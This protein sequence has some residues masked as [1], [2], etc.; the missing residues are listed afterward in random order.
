M[1]LPPAPESRRARMKS[2]LPSFGIRKASKFGPLLE[3][4]PAAKHRRTLE[5]FKAAQPDR[6]I[7]TLRAAL[8]VVSAKLCKGVRQHSGAKRQVAE[9]KEPSPASSASTPPAAAN[10]CSGSARNGAMISPTSS[11]RKCSAP[12]SP[13]WSVISSTRN[14]RT[15]CANSCCPIRIDR[16]SHRHGGHRSGQ[17]P[18]P[19]CSSRRCSRTWTNGPC[20]PAS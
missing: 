15:G 13:R 11:D 7:D 9:L 12:C 18:H 10:C 19:H 5:S 14:A 1:T 20:S 2:P 6:W 8:N 16:R 17:G 3:A 4:I